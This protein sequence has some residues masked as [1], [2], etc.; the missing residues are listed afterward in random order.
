MTDDKDRICPHCRCLMMEQDDDSGEWWCC[1][2]F[3]IGADYEKTKN[4]VRA[5]V[6]GRT[7]GCLVA[8]DV[9]TYGLLLGMDAG[10]MSDN[11]PYGHEDCYMN[12]Q[13]PT[14]EIAHNGIGL[15]TRTQ[16][17]ATPSTDPFHELS[18]IF[19][20]SLN[21]GDDMTTRPHKITLHMSGVDLIR[22]V[23]L[24]MYP[25]GERK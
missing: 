18:C 9:R 15:P 7:H 20:R 13:Q 8:S 11:N 23:Q 25:T 5:E 3:G 14:S 4:G 16:H 17:P 1:T 19:Q 2:C 10:K 24:A 12:T 6:S 22:L 21:N